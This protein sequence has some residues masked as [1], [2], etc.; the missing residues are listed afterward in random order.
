MDMLTKAQLDEDAVDQ[1]PAYLL[2]LDT[3]RAGRLRYFRCFAST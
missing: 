3:V 2:S 1:P